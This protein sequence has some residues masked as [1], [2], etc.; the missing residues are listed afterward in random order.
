M[1][2]PL[3][4]KCIGV[5]VLQEMPEST[6]DMSY[7]EVDNF[8]YTNRK[9]VGGVWGEYEMEESDTD[10]PPTETLDTVEGQLK[11]LQD[12]NLAIQEAIASIYEYRTENT[13][14]IQEAMAS[15]YEMIL[16]MKGV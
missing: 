7:V 11:T 16:E 6:E 9:Y 4:A 2:D 5:T 8:T 13:V 1:V 14:E 12:Q 10:L 15:I 3:K